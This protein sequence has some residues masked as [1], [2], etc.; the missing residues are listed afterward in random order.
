[1][2]LVRAFLL[3]A[4]PFAAACIEVPKPPP[5]AP[6]TAREV[7]VDEGVELSMACVP[8]GIERCFDAWD[9]NCNG[10]IDEGCGL[11]TGILQ[12]TVA[13]D[14]PQ[15]D[16]DL[17]V[18]DPNGDV[19]T[20]GE[21]TAAGL[22][23]DRDC[24]RPECEGQNVENVFLTEGAPKRGKYKVVVRLDKLGGATAPVPVR[25][26]VR[27]GQRTL[28]ARLSLSPGAET[29]TKTFEMTL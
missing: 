29:E 8:T 14:D 17:D 7:R 11:R 25:L 22:L 26:G 1:V 6:L 9:D 4:V 2:R 19:A 18:T 20:V 16:V 23:K 24:P 12:F 13:W 10:V 3:A 21:P 5:P 15:A 27:I 28:G